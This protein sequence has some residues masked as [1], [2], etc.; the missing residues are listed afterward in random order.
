MSVMA[1]IKN[2]ANHIRVGL[3]LSSIAELSS[4]IGVTIEIKE[5]RDNWKVKE[6]AVWNTANTVVAGGFVLH[7]AAVRTCIEWLVNTSEGDT[8]INTAM[9]FTATKPRK[10]SSKSSN[11]RLSWQVAETI[12]ECPLKLAKC[13]SG[14]ICVNFVIES[15]N[16]KLV[17]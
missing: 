17:C 3:T 6:Y 2:V 4:Q 5:S 7:L 12:G 14:D 8:R 13:T 11:S 16:G 15:L 9:D 1:P 10:R